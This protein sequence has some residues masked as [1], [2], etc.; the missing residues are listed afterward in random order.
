MNFEI[1]SIFSKCIQFVFEPN[2]LMSSIGIEQDYFGLIFW[3]IA[4][5]L[6]Q[7]VGWS[8]STASTNH[9]NSVEFLNDF[10]SFRFEGKLAIVV[11]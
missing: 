2:I 5:C 11:E 8:D 4:D 7:L 3:I 10:I 6:N 1:I 9:E